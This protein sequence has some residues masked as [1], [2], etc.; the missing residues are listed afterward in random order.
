MT[1][2]PDRQGRALRAALRAARLAFV[3]ALAGWSAPAFAQRTAPPDLTVEEH[4]GALLALDARFLD[5]EGRP[6]RLGDYYDGRRPALLIFGYHSCPMLCSLIQSAAARAVRDGGWTVGRD[7]DVIMISIDPKDSPAT[8]A[9]RRAAVMSIGAPQTPAAG[10]PSD[11]GWHFLTSPDVAQIDLV[12][13]SAGYRYAFD[14][15]R[16]TYVHPALVLVTTAGGRVARYL[17]GV[18]YR[19]R[20]LRLALAEA[21]AGRS[22]STADRVLLFCT[23]FDPTSGR[24]VIVATR[25]IQVGG[26]LTLGILAFAL[27]VLWA[28]ERRLRSGGSS[29]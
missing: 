8:A 24:Y 1:A 2:V 11:D 29:S 5:H 12:A 23:R 15:A 26:A 17:Y 9:Q 7:F 25:I 22:V 27:T 10:S 21:A 14:E 20:D 16:R 19:S 28:R 4:L 6:V 18:E 3:L 13:R